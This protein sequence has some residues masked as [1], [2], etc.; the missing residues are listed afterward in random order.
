MD[1]SHLPRHAGRLILSV[2]CELD[3]RLAWRTS[4]E[5]P[6][7]RKELAMAMEAEDFRF[8]WEEPRLDVESMELDQFKAYWKLDC[9]VGRPRSSHAFFRM[10]SSG[11]SQFALSHTVQRWDTLG[12]LVRKYDVQVISILLPL[13]LKFSTLLVAWEGNLMSGEVFRPR[14]FFGFRVQFVVV[15]AIFS[16]FEGDARHSFLWIFS[17]I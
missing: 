6:S 2:F 14:L 7:Q 9:I 17:R 5:T 12:S 3:L 10:N 4:E 8:L 16:L 13:C 15:S 11:L 1:V